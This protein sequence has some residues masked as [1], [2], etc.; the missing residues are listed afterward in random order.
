MRVECFA[1]ASRPVMDT[2][3]AVVDFIMHCGETLT[4]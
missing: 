1:Y 4:I 2:S 3:S